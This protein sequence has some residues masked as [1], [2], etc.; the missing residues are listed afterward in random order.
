MTEHSDAMPRTSGHRYKQV[1]I[2]C[3]CTR[4]HTQ[5]KTTRI[6][7]P[8]PQSF[9]SSYTLA[10]ANWSRMRRT[11]ELHNCGAKKCWI[12][13]TN[14]SFIQNVIC[15]IYISLVHKKLRIRVYQGLKLH[16]GLIRWHHWLLFCNIKCSS[17]LG[18]LYTV[19]PKC[20]LH[21]YCC[22]TA[23]EDRCDHQRYWVLPQLLCPLIAF[24]LHPRVSKSRLVSGTC[25]E[26]L[27]SAMYKSRGLFEWHGSR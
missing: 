3:T 19:I 24:K 8:L 26:M 18:C 16:L 7:F 11:L 1:H 2:P 6:H 27:W 14:L 23:A 15:L 25:Q 20:T 13:S 22:N 5:F 17:V 10:W 9:S 4:T 12:S 21:H